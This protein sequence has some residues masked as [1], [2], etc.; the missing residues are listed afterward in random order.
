MFF[1]T[2]ALKAKKE[3][4]IQRRRKG[5]SRKND[6]DQS[7]RSGGGAVLHLHGCRFG[8]F[9]TNKTQSWVLGE[10]QAR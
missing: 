5:Q 8:R 3:V 9:C 4:G 1:M 2:F 7:L 6:H 10:F